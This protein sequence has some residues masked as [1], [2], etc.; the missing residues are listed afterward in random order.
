MQIVISKTI[1]SKYRSTIDSIQQFLNQIRSWNK[2]Q[3][4]FNKLPSKLRIN[5]KTLPKDMKGRAYGD[6]QRKLYIIEIDPRQP[7]DS[8]ITTFFHELAHIKQFLVGSL[9]YKQNEWFWKKE[10][11]TATVDYQLYLDLP[12]EIEA[13]DYATKITTSYHKTFRL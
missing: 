5:V 13:R 8:V 2:L 7:I 1:Y 9:M 12:W 11:Y 6:K 10:K 4:I 3:T